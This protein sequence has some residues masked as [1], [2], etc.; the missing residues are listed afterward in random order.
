MSAFDATTERRRA[1]TAKM[2]A[3]REVS[4]YA[5]E[6]AGDCWKRYEPHCAH[7]MFGE[8]VERDTDSKDC[9]CTCHHETELE[10]D[11]SNLCK[12]SAAHN[13][14]AVDDIHDGWVASIELTK[15]VSCVG[16]SQ[17]QT[18][19]RDNARNESKRA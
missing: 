8:C 12:R 11:A 17:A 16:G 19:N 18:H 2:C 3:E 13:L 4:W 10:E 6:T 1:L 5:Q 7:C 9:S 15:D 14:T